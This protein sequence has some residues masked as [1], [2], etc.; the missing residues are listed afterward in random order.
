MLF[1]PLL[2]SVLGSLRD[3]RESSS[4]SAFI[5]LFIQLGGSIASATLV[6][7]LDRR[8]DLHLDTLNAFVSLTNIPIRNLIVGAHGLTQAIA[9]QISALIAQQAAAFAYADV[10]LLVAVL[11][12]ISIP[13]ILG[14]PKPTTT[15]VVIEVG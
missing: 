11:T 2:F 7:F 10:F 8:E 5:N 4:V 9:A 15:D 12:L 1:V 14:I 3:A 13:L 6:T